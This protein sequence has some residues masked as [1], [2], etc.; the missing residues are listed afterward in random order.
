M[1]FN[2][3]NC[4]ALALL[5][6]LDNNINTNDLT[7]KINTLKEI[8]TNNVNLVGRYISSVAFTGQTAVLAVTTD[9]ELEL[10]NKL[11]NQGFKHI[12]SFKRRKGYPEGILKL[13]V[14]DLL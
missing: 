14:L 10:E 8:A 13:W 12:H 6:S 11:I 4:C 7:Q 1:N 5:S 2:S 3:T 9:R